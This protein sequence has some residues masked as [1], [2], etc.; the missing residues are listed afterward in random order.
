M[1]H[2]DSSSHEP[3]PPRQ[4]AIVRGDNGGGNGGGGLGDGGGGEGDGGAGAGDGGGGEGGGAGGLDGGL[5][6]CH[7][8]VKSV[9]LSV[10]P[11]RPPAR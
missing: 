2:A 9:M 10:C 4:L 5:G 3:V 7:S 6:N 8:H 1:S 11:K